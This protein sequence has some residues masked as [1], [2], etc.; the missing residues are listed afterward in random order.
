MNHEEAQIRVLQHSDNDDFVPTLDPAFVVLGMISEYM[1]R[2]AIEGGKT[3]ER[4]YVDERPVADLFA[5]YLVRYAERLC[6][7]SR[8]ISVT[9]GDSDHSYVE[10]KRMNDQVN[11]LYRFEYQDEQVI[12]MLD[13]ERLRCAHVALSIDDFPQK[14]SM[15]Y[16]PDAMDARFS[17]LYGVLLRYGTEGGVI[18]IA[19][20]SEKVELVQQV[21]VDL[22][23]HWISHRYSVG[24]APCCHEVSFEP[25]PRLVSFLD[26]A[27]AERA[28]AFAAAPDRDTSVE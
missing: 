10:S 5:S 22:D 23:V 16:E 3:V 14:R 19:N 18:R 7:D 24:T 12:T 1:G 9:H 26:R 11:A 13:G 25:R 28:Q 4:F 8:E 2:Q 20:A 6:I 21:L 17:Y 15:L 27:R